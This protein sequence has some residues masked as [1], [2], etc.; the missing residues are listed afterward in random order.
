MPSVFKTW[1]RLLP[2]SLKRVGR[3]IDVK[4]LRAFNRF[5]NR[6]YSFFNIACFADG[7]NND[8]SRSV[9]NILW[10]FLRHGKGILAC[11]NVDSEFNGKLADGFYRFVQTRI[12][13]FIF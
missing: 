8:G 12:L 3:K 4:D 2:P 7:R 9:Y 11:W 13:T 6:G 1:A 10:I 5:N